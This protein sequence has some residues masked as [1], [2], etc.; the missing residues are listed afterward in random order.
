MPSL[1]EI[2]AVIAVFFSAAH[3]VVSYHK[4]NHIFSIIHV[5]IAFSHF[6]KLVASGN[7]NCNSGGEYVMAIFGRFCGLLLC[8]LPSNHGFFRWLC[9]E[10]C[11][12]NN[13][14]FSPSPIPL[15]FAK[16]LLAACAVTLCG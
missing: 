13:W 10:I 7:N 15:R 1:A 5:A 4:E 2:L 11:K 6:A 12:T 3:R 9:R 14:N 16:V 8:Q